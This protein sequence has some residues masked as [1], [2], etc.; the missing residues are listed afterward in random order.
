M[1][2]KIGIIGG[3][4]LYKIAGI[5]NIEETAISTPFGKP[6]DKYIIAEFYNEKIAFLPRHGVGHRLTPSELNYRANI[7][8]FKKLGVEQIIA[9]S[10]VGSLKEEIA[11]KDVVIPHQFFDRTSKRICTFFGEGITAHVPFA[12]PVC[13]D[14]AKIVYEAAKTSGAK[15]HWGGTYLNMEGPQF[16]TLA[17]SNLYRQWGM[18]IIGMT[19]LC[20]AK[21]AREAEMCYTTMAMVTD[22]DCWHPEHESVSIEMIIEHLVNNVDTA[23]KI[24]KEIIIRLPEERECRCRH[25]LKDTIV[26]DPKLIP[27]ATKKKLELII[28]KYVK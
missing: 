1:Q 28:G 11:P 22:Y 19:N 21:L 23:H 25:A 2:P 16:S 9:V 26:S 8:G 15:V 20:E 18:D 5:K 17:E 6:S 7:Y 4:G 3:S 10:A 13:L 12:K 24:L 14:L 27:P